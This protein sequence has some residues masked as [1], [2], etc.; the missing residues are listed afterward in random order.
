[1]RHVFIYILLLSLT[2]CNSNKG[3][4]ASK[5]K[6]EF[7]IEQFQNNKDQDNF[8]KGIILTS[9]HEVSNEIKFYDTLIVKT[10]KFVPRHFYCKEYNYELVFDPREIIAFCE[11]SIKEGNNQG[12]S[13]ERIFEIQRLAKASLKGKQVKFDESFLTE[14]LPA[15]AP[16]VTNKNVAI[17][18]T[19]ILIKL[20]KTSC[21]SSRRRVDIV[22]TKGDTLNLYT[23]LSIC[24]N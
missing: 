5:D 22:T 1:M 11:K 7:L 24:M 12:A 4:E 23:N 6:K 3:K 14:L 21:D 13:R 18:P 16:Y 9:T 2:C 19:Q 15:C 10:K 17:K 20:F 8:T